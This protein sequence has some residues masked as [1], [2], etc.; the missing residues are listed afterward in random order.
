MAT[1]D[2]Q[3]VDAFNKRVI[4]LDRGLVKRHRQRYFIETFLIFRV[5]TTISA[6]HIDSTASIASVLPLTIIIVF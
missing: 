2:K 6:K 5:H 1:H 3:V 4:I